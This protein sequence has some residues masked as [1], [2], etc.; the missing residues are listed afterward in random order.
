ML[1]ID[2]RMYFMM[3]KFDIN[4]LDVETR[5]KEQLTCISEI[6]KKLPFGFVFQT[7]MA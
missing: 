5:A 7:A 6:L 4:Q 1:M 2:V 3:T